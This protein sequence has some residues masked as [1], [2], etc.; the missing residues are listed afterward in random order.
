MQIS[1]AN[2]L[3]RLS[4]VCLGTQN[5]ASFAHAGARHRAGWLP[6]CPA[7]PLR[8]APQRLCACAAASRART[9][10]ASVFSKT[11]MIFF[12]GSGRAAWLHHLLFWQVTHFIL[13]GE[14]ERR[15]QDHGKRNGGKK[16]KATLYIWEEERRKEDH[17]K[18]ERR[19]QLHCIFAL[20]VPPN[21]CCVT[22]SRLSA[23]LLASVAVLLTVLY[24]H[25]RTPIEALN[26]RSTASPRS[27]GRSPSS[28][29]PGVRRAA[30]C[31]RSFLPNSRKLWG[32]S[33]DRLRGGPGRPEVRFHEGFHQG[34]TRV[35]E[36]LR[37]L[38]GGASTPHAV[39]DI[40]RAFSSPR[41]PRFVGKG[42]EAG[43]NGNLETKKQAR[44]L[45]RR[46]LLF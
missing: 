41:P 30:R 15:K 2:F 29:S 39:G 37:G 13:Y 24:G 23:V 45:P 4:N 25:G 20:I 22:G 31:R 33:P 38:R 26:R 43:A 42:W 28:H 35:H 18:R 21:C 6:C 17:G 44:H 16:K 46:S 1:L 9:C 7:P 36:V 5:T 10:G 40:T 32:L 19:T 3:K 14:E 8:D 27:P 12:S 34:S 11:T